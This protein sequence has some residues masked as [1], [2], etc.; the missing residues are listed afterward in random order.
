MAAFPRFVAGLKDV[1]RLYRCVLFDVG[2]LRVHGDGGLWGPC[3]AGA[4]H[5][6]SELLARD[7]RVGVLSGSPL[8]AK[9]IKAAT[10]EGG[11]PAEVAAW[12]SGEL[13]CRSLDG[14]L[15]HEAISALPR[16]PKVFELGIFV[17]PQR[18]S[19]TARRGA[20]P[21]EALARAG[22]LKRVESIEDAN[23]CYWDAQEGDKLDHWLEAAVELC[24][25]LKVPLLQPKWGAAALDAVAPLAGRTSGTVEAVSANMRRFG[26]QV[27]SVGKLDKCFEGLGWDDLAPRD[28]LLVTSSLGDLVEASQ[29]G[30]DVLLLFGSRAQSELTAWRQIRT[31]QR[32][33]KRK[34][35]SVS[36]R[37]SED[38]PG[39]MAA[40]TNPF[41]SV[42]Q[43]PSLLA[44]ATAK[45]LKH[46]EKQKE[47][48]QKAA[49]AA[50][51][52]SAVGFEE[53]PEVPVDSD[54]DVDMTELLGDWCQAMRV[55]KPIAL[56]EA[57]SAGV[58][59][60]APRGGAFGTASCRAEVGG[61]KAA[62][63]RSS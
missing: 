17:K 44:E 38:S 32:E 55:E 22:H 61:T 23:L 47:R 41:L 59:A 63:A 53:A 36:Q 48:Q 26:G 24:A 57:S 16:P 30:T 28:A 3:S 1:A 49:S 29:V 45:N 20:P 54:T 35:L 7:K 50:A 37:V 19:D 42:F 15:A 52:R 6:A 33:E 62:G 43:L 9:V 34:N 5:S 51:A 2:A 46:R 40:A 21:L 8:R 56:A 39:L 58:A 27:I 10:C 18:W 13:I 31:Q 60:K 25:D 4:L 12:T 11:L 14:S